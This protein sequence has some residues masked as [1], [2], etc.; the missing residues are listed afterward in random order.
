MDL[1]S[2]DDWLAAEALLREIFPPG[3]KEPSHLSDAC[4]E[5][6]QAF[7]R[8]LGK[9]VW[10]DCVDM[11]LGVSTVGE[12]VG[13]ELQGGPVRDFDGLFPE[14]LEWAADVDAEQVDVAATMLMEAVVRGSSRTYASDEAAWADYRAVLAE[15]QPVRRLLERAPLA[16][17]RWRTGSW[18][19]SRPTAPMRR[20]LLEC[21]R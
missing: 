5:S 11:A 18:G 3:S 7:A 9:D 21:L 4:A 12:V 2:R 15:G 19:F 6:A 8:L 10:I 16:G 13:R 17:R 20:T 1:W 14:V